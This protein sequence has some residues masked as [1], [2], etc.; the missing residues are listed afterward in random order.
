MPCDNVENGSLILCGVQTV[1]EFTE[2][3][4]ILGCGRMTCRGN[5]EVSNVSKTA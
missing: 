5:L 4:G 3:G 1:V 2:Q